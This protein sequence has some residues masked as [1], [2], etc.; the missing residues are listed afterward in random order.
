MENEF[1]TLKADEIE[2]RIQS[3]NGFNDQVKGNFLLFFT[4]RT[5][6]QLLNEAY[7][8]HWKREHFFLTDSEKNSFLV[9]RISIYD[10]CLNTWISREDV[11]TEGTI[12]NEKEK[13]IFSDS[14]KRAI[15]SFGLT[16][17]YT[18]PKIDIKLEPEEYYTKN[19]KYYLKSNVNFRVNEV[20]YNEVRQIIK[21]SIVDQNNKIRFY[22]EEKQTPELTGEQIDLITEIFDIVEK[23][24]IDY[25]KLEKSINKKYN[26]P[27]LELEARELKEVIKLL[28]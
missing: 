3:I 18:A 2:L 7:G 11:G 15:V 24:S 28:N 9:C 20:C 22:Y 26:K 12:S 6:V 16:E 5:G 25:S 13:S 1:R 14:F 19:N 17:L 10:K 27:L 8:N 23:S 4:A 21:L